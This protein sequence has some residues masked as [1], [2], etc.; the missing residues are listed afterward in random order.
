ME[1]EKR[2]KILEKYKSLNKLTLVG[3]LGIAYFVPALVVPA[4]VTA[5]IDLAQIITIDKFNKKKPSEKVVFQAQA[6]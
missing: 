3:A 6:A 1:S 4:L 2:F 5:G